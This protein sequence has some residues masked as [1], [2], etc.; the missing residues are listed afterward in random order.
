M[1][2]QYFKLT[3]GNEEAVFEEFVCDVLSGMNTYG[4][5]F[6][7]V[8][9]EYNSA[10]QSRNGYTAEDYAESIDAGGKKYN[11]SL[12]SKLKNAQEII[13]NLQLAVELTGKEF[14]KGNK[15]LTEQVN[16]YFESIGGKAYNPQ[17]GEVLLTNRGI[18]DSIAHG[19]GR[20]K[21]LTFAAVP[22][23]IEKGAIIDYEENWKDR[24]Y[25]TYVIAAPI[26]IDGSL[27][28]VGVVVM[29][30]KRTHRYY[31]HE[32]LTKND[33]PFKTGS[34]ENSSEPGG[35]SSVNT[36]I[37]QNDKS[38]NDYDTENLRKYSS[39]TERT[40]ITPE[41]VKSVQSIGRKSVN[42]FTT[43]DIAKTES[44]AKKVL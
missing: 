24:G 19:V 14:P 43:E 35:T 15:K 11:N 34:G 16:E 22:S 10:V 13:S 29:E 8:A 42:D 40:D 41:D 25:N 21:A 39:E 32:A 7:D 28:H 33:V 9:A 1:Y 4:H 12:V 18:K 36:N 30:D 23:V 38:V 44:F 5:K 31:L 2:S 3:D 17:I 6:D 26:M 20:T 37:S 27:A